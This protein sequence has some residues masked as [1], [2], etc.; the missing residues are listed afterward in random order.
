VRSASSLH[1][2]GAFPQE[3]PQ[4]ERRWLHPVAY[5]SMIDIVPQGILVRDMAWPATRVVRAS[6]G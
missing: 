1:S 2:L 5:A 6:A 3:E 4:S